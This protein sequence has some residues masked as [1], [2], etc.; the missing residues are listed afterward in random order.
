MFASRAGHSS[1]WHPQCFQCASCSELLVDLI[2]FYQ[3][4]QIYCGRHHA[5]RLKPRCQACDE[6]NI[7]PTSLYFCSAMNSQHAQGFVNYTGTQRA[8]NNVICFFSCEGD[9]NIL[10]VKVFFPR[11]NIS[12]F[13]LITAIVCRYSA[14]LFII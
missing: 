9:D 3:E 14:D 13:S 7:S 8:K 11:L 4:G 6:V 12:V 1:C 2:Y 10:Y 5:E